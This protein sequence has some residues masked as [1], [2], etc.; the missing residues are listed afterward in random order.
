MRII[1]TIITLLCLS[2][3]NAQNDKGDFKALACDI[4]ACQADEPHRHSFGHYL[5]QCSNEAEVIFTGFFLGYKHFFSSQDSRSCTFEPSCSV[6]AIETIRKNGL[7]KGF[8]DSVD[9]LTRCNGLSPGNYKID[10]QKHLLIDN[11]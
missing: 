1:F 10:Q 3:A 4:I 8:L 7:I 2:S 11:P 9:R 5:E 6:Y